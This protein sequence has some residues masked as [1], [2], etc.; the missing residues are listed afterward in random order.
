M[1]IRRDAGGRLDIQDLIDRLAQPAQTDAPSKTPP[2]FSVTNIVIDEGRFVF[3]DALLRER[4]EVRELALRIPFVSSLPVDEEVHVEPSLHALV[5]GAR[6]ELAGES[7]PFS[8]TRD[9]T[10][11]F[12]L[13][14]L[15]LTRFIGYVPVP[16]PVE[17]HSAHLDTALTLVFSQAV[18][19]MPSIA[20]NGRATLDTLD[21]REPGG[22][23]LLAAETIVADGISLAWPANRYAAERITI[24]APSASVARRADAHRFLE[25]V[26]AAM[27]RSGGGAVTAGSARAPAADSEEEG[28]PSG[29]EIDAGPAAEPESTPPLAAE[30]P[31]STTLGSTQRPDAARP[32]IDWWIGEIVLENGAIA[33]QDAQFVPRALQLEASAVEARIRDLSS[34]PAMA[35][36]FE[37][38][39]RLDH[40]EQLRAAGTSAWQKGEVDADLDVKD[41]SPGDWWW[42]AE[43]WLDFNVASGR[44]ALQTHLRIEA[45]EQASSEPSIRFQDT[46]LQID[47]LALHQDP[48]QRTLLSLPRLELVAGTVEISSRTIELGSLATRGGQLLVQRN[49]GERQFNVQRLL[50]T[51]A[52]SGGAVAIQQRPAGA[53]AGDRSR[54][55]NRDGASAPWTVTLGKLAVQGFA[56]DLQDQQGSGTA[57]LPIHDLAISARDLS[58]VSGAAPARVSLQARLGRRGALSVSGEAGLDPMLAQWQVAVRN[59]AL[60]PL[61]PWAAEFSNADIA[62]GTLNAEGRL[63][64]A[65]PAQ[66]KSGTAGPHIRWNGRAGIAGLS[67]GIRGSEEKL[68]D[69]KSLTVDGITF[70]SATMAT[71]LDKITL[72]GLQA[73]I[74]LDAQGQLNLRA[75][76]SSPNDGEANSAATTNHASDPASTPVKA[77]TAVAAAAGHASGGA[78]TGNGTLRIGGIHLVDGDVD[79]SDFFIQPNYSARLSDLNGQ[80][81]QIVAGQ[82]GELELHG[83]VNQTG[84]LELAGQIDALAD[85]LRLDLK[86]TVDDVDLPGLSPYS[87]KYVGYGIEKGKLSAQLAYRLDHRELTAE[88]HVILNQL[89]FGNAVESPDALDLPVLFAVSL[90]KDRNGVIDV[91]LPVS[92]SLDDPQ[93]SISGIVLR[94]IG[95]LIVKTVTAPFSL[96]ANL[97]G[98]SGAELSWIGFVAGSAMLD[99]SAIDKLQKI[100]AALTDRPGLKL[101]LAGH[102]DPDVDRE[103]LRQRALRQAVAA[104]RRGSAQ[105]DQTAGEADGVAPI[106]PEKYPVYLERAWKAAKFDKPRN[107]IGLVKKQPVAE[108]ERMMLEHIEVGDVELAALGNERAQQVK[109]WLVERGGISGE[110][111]FIVAAGKD[112]KSGARTQTAPAAGPNETGGMQAPAADTASTSTP[113]STPTSMRVDLSLK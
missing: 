13:E 22:T 33:V 49:H 72:E 11:E 104:Q 60:A 36:G 86:A 55:G 111:I 6:F 52:V 28:D 89:T 4:H 106:D 91:N 14:D 20:L 46:A 3:D 43:P 32:A 58:T 76:M 109:D 98:G 34:D 63:R 95:N 108:M 102:I 44:L 103:G 105:D 68:L 5:D 82:A 113:A 29:V 9:S 74:I 77:T 27:E 41:V 15:D 2:R 79:F 18:G 30:N 23:P 92:G 107:A 84:R 37:L 56:I 45:P 40:G 81:S 87:G 1:R 35:A 64:L 65:M 19:A 110:R 31:A 101:D 50:K 78:E 66:T 100:A 17:V 48:G 90:L 47:D 24:Q 80:I 73:R 25:P 7:L 112:E 71:D 53:S 62:S 10:L 69:W 67:A 8:P 57:R 99:D 54:R 42:I 75:L 85:P 16:L 61:Q 12:A 94:I 51:P 97:A 39:F 26:L 38:G 21:I 93:F 96:L 83:R 88:N 59:L 70:D